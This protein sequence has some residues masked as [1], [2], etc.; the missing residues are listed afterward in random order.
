MDIKDPSRQ[1]VPI[2]FI[3]SYELTAL[4]FLAYRWARKRYQA[5]PKGYESPSPATTKE[6]DLK[7]KKPELTPE[8]KAERHRRRVH[9][10]KLI[11]GLFA[12][13]MLQSLDTTIIASA[14]PFIAA[15]F[16]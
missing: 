1:E 13:F 8:D 16:Q 3:Q 12:P 10:W 4:M 9:R 6:H 11:L 5:R 7:S 2:T 15:D 14:L